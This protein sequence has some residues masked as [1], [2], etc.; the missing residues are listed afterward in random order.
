MIIRNYGFGDLIILFMDNNQLDEY[1]VGV[2]SNGNF[3]DGWDCFVGEKTSRQIKVDDIDIKEDV[4]WADAGYFTKDN[5]EG[6]FL[7]YNTLLS[8]RICLKIGLPLGL[9]KQK[10]NEEREIAFC[11]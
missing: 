2:S 5:G 7:D 8:I 6:C 9:D 3:Y 11:Y 4:A 1:W 10:Q